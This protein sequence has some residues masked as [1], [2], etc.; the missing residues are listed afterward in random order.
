MK[1]PGQDRAYWHGERVF[2]VPCPAC[3]STVEFFRDE[4]S[5]RCSQCAHRISNPRVALDCATWC[6]QAESCMGLSRS[7]IA[8][9]GQ[10]DTALAGRLIQGLEEAIPN[11]PA[12]IARALLVFQHARELAAASAANPVVLLSAA[13]LLELKEVM[14]RDAGPSSSLSAGD[15][16]ASTAC[17]DVLLRARLGDEAIDT[18][19]ALLDDFHHRRN[20]GREEVMVLRDAVTLADMSAARP[21]E[22]GQLERQI[23]DGL[24]TDAGKARARGLW[25]SETTPSIGARQETP[26]AASRSL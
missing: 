7:R 9:L 20:D 14:E 24:Q 17:R 22:A 10:E 11:E 13:L 23:C 18:I 16:T 19:A 21:V 3:G 12:R 25:L 4:V 1:C 26:S 15:F 6:D 5:R 8:A 2:E